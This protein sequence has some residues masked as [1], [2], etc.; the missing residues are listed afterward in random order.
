MRHTHATKE[1]GRF[2]N[3]FTD[4]EYTNDLS[5]HIPGLEYWLRIQGI[6]AI[7]F[8][9]DGTRPVILKKTVAY[10]GVDENENGIVFE[11]WAIKNH[12]QYVNK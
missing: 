12:V 2:E 11:K 3:E 4:F 7:I 9:A 8:V 6:N 5:Q 10:V 1:N